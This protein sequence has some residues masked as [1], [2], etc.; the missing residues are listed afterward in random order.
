MSN[1]ERLELI[2]SIRQSRT[3]SKVKPEKAVK[4][5]KAREAKQPALSNLDILKTLKEAGLI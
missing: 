1:N 2:L 3:T 5:S 4:E